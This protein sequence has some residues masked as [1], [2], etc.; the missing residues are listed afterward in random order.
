MINLTNRLICYIQGHT[1]ST[2]IAEHNHYTG[3]DYLYCLRC[4]AYLPT[5]EIE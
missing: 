4:K 3:Q 1:I 5:Q 2:L